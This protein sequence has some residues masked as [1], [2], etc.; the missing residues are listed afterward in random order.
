[1]L[2]YAYKFGDFNKTVTIG[3]QGLYVNERILRQVLQV[4][5]EYNHEEFCEQL[6]KEY[7]HSHTVDSIDASNFENAS[8]LHDMNNPL[9]ENLRQQYDTIIDAGTL[10]H[11]YNIPQALEN[12]SLLCRPGGQ[13]IHMLPAN[14]NCGHGFWQVS[15][16]LFFSLYTNENGYR[17]TEVFLTY[18]SPQKEISWYRVKKPENGERINIYSSNEVYVF[19]RTVLHE[20]IFSH[21]NIQQSDYL[22]LWN[23]NSIKQ[24]S[25]WKLIINKLISRHEYLYKLITPLYSFY[26]VRKLSSRLSSSNPHLIKTNISSLLRDDEGRRG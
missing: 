1:M 12:C 6:L 25:K 21:R 16:E 10:E 22:F 2:R 19:V 26:Y 20:K 18:M 15:P 17:D 14:N 24:K 8:I 3:R 7:F 4:E 5:T 9:P 11:I 13:I 23:K